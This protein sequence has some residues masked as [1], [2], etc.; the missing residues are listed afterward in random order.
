MYFEVN[1]IRRDYGCVN[2]IA[3]R[4]VTQPSV[5]CNFLGQNCSIDHVVDLTFQLKLHTYKLNTSIRLVLSKVSACLNQNYR[6]MYCRGN[7]FPP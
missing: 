1:A 3:L 6:R 4:R 5:K 7:F 2:F